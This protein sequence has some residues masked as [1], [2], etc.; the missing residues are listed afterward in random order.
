MFDWVTM[1]HKAYEALDPTRR[2]TPEQFARLDHFSRIES[3]APRTPLRQRAAATLMRL[4]IAL[5]GHAQ[6]ALAGLPVTNQR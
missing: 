6:A 2:F 3:E 4:A 1:E 5:D